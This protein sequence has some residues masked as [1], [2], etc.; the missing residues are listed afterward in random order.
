MPPAPPSRSAGY[1]RARR[2]GPTLTRRA[3]GPSDRP[4]LQAPTPNPCAR[5]LLATACVHNGLKQAPGAIQS[6]LAHHPPP[7]KARD[8]A[9]VQFNTVYLPRPA[10]SRLPSAVARQINAIRYTW[11][12][13]TEPDMSKLLDTESLL[14]SARVDLGAAIQREVA[15]REQCSSTVPTP[16][17]SQEVGLLGRYSVESIPAVAGRQ[18]PLLPSRWRVGSLAR[19]A[20]KP[21]AAIVGAPYN[22]SLEGTSPSLASMSDMFSGLAPQLRRSAS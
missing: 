21:R 22:Q 18:R 14:V 4:A 6:P 9:M 5:A 2:D 1:A 16:S 8:G 17:E 15:A 11:L 12:F 10:G 13:P 20:C 7:H 3:T 19:L